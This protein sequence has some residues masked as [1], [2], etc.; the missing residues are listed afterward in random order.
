MQRFF[1]KVKLY[2]KTKELVSK[3]ITGWIL[4]NGPS[5]I[6]NVNVF[7]LNNN[8]IWQ[9]ALPQDIK[10][11]RPGI[12]KKYDLKENLNKYVGFIG[13]QNNKEYMVY[14][15]KDTENKRTTGF[16]C[17]QSG[18]EKI[19]KILNEIEIN[20]KYIS[21]VTKEGVFELC[22]RQEFTLRSLEYQERYK[23]KNKRTV[24]FLDTETAIINE[25]EKKEKS[26]K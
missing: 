26:K 20:D 19:M 16:S 5:R 18:K 10:D 22:V 11:L 13:F 3:G 4:F 9:P 14:K 24:Y 23:S 6:E 17:N 25:F 7:V 2:L 8:N 15:V 12:E 1:G 21:K